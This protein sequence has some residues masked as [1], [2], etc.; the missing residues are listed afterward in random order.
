MALY[1]IQSV[2]QGNAYPGY[3]TAKLL[4]TVNYV[5]ETKQINCSMYT[6]IGF[7][8]LPPDGDNVTLRKSQ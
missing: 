3:S 5:Y 4:L 8:R 2:L 1:F 6:Y 7:Q